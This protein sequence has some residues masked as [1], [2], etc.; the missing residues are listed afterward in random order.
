[1]VNGSWMVVL[2]SY[3]IVGMKGASIEGDMKEL[4]GKLSSRGKSI[5]EEAGLNRLI[6]LA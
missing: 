3:F 5:I 2:I 1:M 4:L 6:G